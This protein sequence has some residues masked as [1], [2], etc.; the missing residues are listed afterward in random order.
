MVNVTPDIL[1]ETELTAVRRRFD[2]RDRRW[3]LSCTLI[4]AMISF[5]TFTSAFVDSRHRTMRLTCGWIEFL[6]SL[7]LFIALVPL[8]FGN[9]SKPAPPY[10]RALRQI[11]I[12]YFIVMYATIIISSAGASQ[13]IAFAVVVPFLLIG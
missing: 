4:F 13:W 10:A 12:V 1:N 5:I 3:G 11:L 6:V 2:G 7:A 8:E 9:K